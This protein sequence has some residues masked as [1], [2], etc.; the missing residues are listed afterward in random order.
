MAE[1]KGV[2]FSRFL[3]LPRVFL[4]QTQRIFNTTLVD[5]LEK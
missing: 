1:Y 2:W 3:H 4:S 5:Y